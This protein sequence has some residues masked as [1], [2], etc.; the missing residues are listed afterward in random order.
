MDKTL[1]M[2]LKAYSTT[3]DL[4]FQECVTVRNKLMEQKASGVISEF[5]LKCD[6]SQK[7]GTCHTKRDYKIGFWGRGPNNIAELKFTVP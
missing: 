7:K 6:S 1:H 5:I 4:Y 2:V 3:W